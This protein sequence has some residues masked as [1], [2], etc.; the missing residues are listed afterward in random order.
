MESMVYTKVI[1]NTQ[2]VCRQVFTIHN[3]YMSVTN[4]HYELD[5]M[6]D[7]LDYDEKDLHDDEVTIMDD[8]IRKAE[9]YLSHD[10]IRKIQ[11]AY[12]YAAQAH[13]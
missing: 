9:K 12:I 3:L 8:I 5:S 6:E 10:D 13:K 7:F 2:P 11:K 4:H 1:H